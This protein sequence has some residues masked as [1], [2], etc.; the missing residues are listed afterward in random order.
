MAIAAGANHTCA[1]LDNATVRCWGLGASGRLG[2]GNTSNVGDYQTPGSVGPV[3]LGTGQTAAAISAGGRH[4]CALLDNARVRCWGYGGNGQLGYCNVSDVGN[5]QTPGS[6]GPVNLVPGDGGAQC[7]RPPASASPA[8]GPPAGANPSGMPPAID[9]EAVRARGFRA[10]LATLAARAK[11]TRA[12]THRGSKRARAHARRRLSRLLASGRRQCIRL[13]GS[14]PG[15]VNGLHAMTR[16]P[17]RIE[18]DF[19]APGTNANLPPAATTYLIK[20]SLRPIRGERDFTAAHALCHGV[21]SFTV[22]GIGAKIALTVSGLRTHTV[23]YYAIA[24]RDNVTGRLGP[25]TTT[26][27]AKTS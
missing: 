27:T 7:P 2:Y 25:R 18:L 12:L 17:S 16:G 9:T 8:A 10:C 5:T 15:L 24:A 14:T 26:V 6:A 1:I 13:W 23:Y 11:H 4:T 21:C 22:T 3:D 20:Q 19:T